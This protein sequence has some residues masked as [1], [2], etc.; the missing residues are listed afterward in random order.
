MTKRQNENWMAAGVEAW[1]LGFEMWSV[2]GLRMMK[3]AAGGA[4]GESESRI[5]IEEKMQAMAELQTKLLT[6]RISS[7][8]ATGSRQVMRHYSGKVKANRR[9]LG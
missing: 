9:R 8:L 3:I 4:A 1:A 6:G 7:D 5:M 2:M